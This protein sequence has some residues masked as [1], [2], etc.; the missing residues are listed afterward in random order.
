M[1]AAYTPWDYL[2]VTASNERQ[3]E[4]YREQLKARTELG[5]L[6]EIGH[7]LVV[8]DPGGRRVGS[9]GSTLICLLEVLRRELPEPMRNDPDSW[10][11]ALRKL[12]ILIVH[13]GGDS[14]RLPPYGPSGKIFVPVPGESDHTLS[15]TIFDRQVPI[16]LALPPNRPSA[17]QVVIATGDVLL[18][19]DPKRVRFD[20]PGITGLGSLSSPE[21]ASKH[22]VFCPGIGSEVRLFLQKPTPE[23]QR[24]AGAIDRHG[25]SVLDIGVMSLDAESCVRL[26]QLLDLKPDSSG[27]LQPTA[28]ETGPFSAVGFNFYREI[29]CGLGREGT[30]RHFLESCRLGGSSLSDETLGEIYRAIRDIPFHL[31]HVPHCRFMHFGT[32]KQLITTGHDLIS[33][34][35][36]FS[37]R[38]QLLEMN[39]SCSSEGMLSGVDGWVEGCRVSAP[40]HLDGNNVLVGAD[41]VSP[42][43]LP[44]GACLDIVEGTSRS[45][46]PV[47]FVRW[48]GIEDLFSPTL[49]QGGTYSNRPLREW[50]EAV[51]ITESDVWSSDVPEAKRSLWSAQ[52]FPAVEPGSEFSQWLWMYAP[53]SADE[54][55][56][57]A[58]LEADRYSCAEIAFLADYPRFHSRR[59]VNRAE[60]LKRQVGRL[61]RFS[62]G[63]SAAELTLLMAQES[64]AGRIQIISSVLDYAYKSLVL[65]EGASGLDQLDLCRI[66]HTMGTAICQ[67]AQQVD[68]DVPVER[69][70]VE[71]DEEIATWIGLGDLDAAPS[72]FLAWG[73]QLQERAFW[74]LGQTIVASSREAVGLPR[75]V[76]RSDEIVWGRAP[77]RLDLGGGWSDTPPYALER[78]GCVI[79]AA[80]DLNGQ[81]PI[82]AYA[83]ILDQPEIRIA[84]IDHSTRVTIRTLEE[85]TDYNVRI[86]GFSLAKAALALSGFS[87]EWGSWPAGVTT[88]EQVLKHF[89]GG[90]ELTTLAAIPSGSGL[91]TSSIMGAVL[92]S[93]LNRVLGAELDQREL[94]NKV[95]QLEQELTTGGGWQD[96]IGGV[97]GGVK[98]IRTEPGLIPSPRISFVTDDLLCP[99]S[100]GHQTLLY[101]TGI[102]RMAKNIL[103]DVVG[104][105]LNR[106]RASA[107]TLRRIHALPEAVSDALSRRDGPAFG[108]LIDVA[109]RLN[110]KL[111]PGSTTPEVE[112]ILGRVQPHLWG[113]KLLGAGGGG[114][115]LLVCK[116]SQDANQVRQTLES[117]P[118]NDRARF[119]QFGINYQGLVVT[120][121]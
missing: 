84:S 1:P 32:L 77:A 19:F 46:K 21:Q 70:R 101:Y 110:N 24:R 103:K 43:T 34:D 9:G 60:E 86:D 79:N 36:G 44:Q 42:L 17:G 90:I 15:Y 92:M 85:L 8:P 94:F 105:Y 12:R 20:F 26:L 100:N 108:K 33:L 69:I 13:A 3:S 53:E 78:G 51:G 102:R 117:D 109:W 114:F 4:S 104:D 27:E 64:E 31:C 59:M 93:V 58:W 73:K 57:K 112:S 107:V 54:T 23:E 47:E 55:Q 25:R 88:L 5:F 41:I 75:S 118:P 74:T 87:P 115:L 40:L 97:V 29:C 121:C 71:L 106:D 72:G 39:N 80:V 50:L 116:S 28:L 6:S 63:F 66:L 11:E 18:D 119:F 113:A 98:V 48:Y 82:H 111:D 22:G 68:W 99:S 67:T 81:P 16:Y 56:R 95:L 76:L 96:Q 61:F 7:V 38:Q 14:K 2:I 62:S 65:E 83:R 45:G 30:E 49:E 52:L 89:G 10:V 120:V 91:G 37:A 35:Q